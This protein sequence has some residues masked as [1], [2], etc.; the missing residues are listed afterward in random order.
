MTT[1][2][3]LGSA[4][5]VMTLMI[6]AVV[7]V[8][9]VVLPSQPDGMHI[10]GSATRSYIN[11]SVQNQSRGYIYYSEMNMSQMSNKWIAYVGNIS[12]T[13]AIMDPA[14]Y[15]LYDWQ[16]T[17]L[18]GEVYATKESG[19]IA[20]TADLYAGGIPNW[21][22]MKCANSSMLNR[23]T[24]EFNHSGSDVD[25]LNNTFTTANFQTPTFYVGET[26]IMDSNPDTTWG[27][28]ST[29]SGLNLYTYSNDP[30]E[31]ATRN[32]TQIV[33]SDGTL[34]DSSAST[35]A[36]KQYDI[37]YASLIQN[38]SAGYNGGRYDFQMIL[39][40]SGLAGTVDNIAFYF[41]VE[42]S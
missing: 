23:E 32:W 24:K 13:Y 34:E 29:C 4:I 22:V 18:T 9:A 33:L 16:I 5:L 37:T 10:E 35:M 40:Q 30:G 21:A 38:Y 14:G 31:T 36:H 39:P 8:Y 28:E 26:K 1:I 27:T 19:R 7:S 3:N 2:K 15:K 41:Y 25:R 20:S 17:D 6:A 42:L 11:G 12:G